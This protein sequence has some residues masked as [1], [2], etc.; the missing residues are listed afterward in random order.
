MQA[1]VRVVA[2]VQEEVGLELALVPEPAARAPG[3]ALEEARR[4]WRLQPHPRPHTRATKRCPTPQ[5]QP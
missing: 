1:L 3:Q 2:P 4:R 5:Q